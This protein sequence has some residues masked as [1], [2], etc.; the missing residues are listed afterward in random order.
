M[1]GQVKIG[2]E[3][4][5]KAK[6]DY[7]DWR[8]AW[9]RELAQNSWDIP[10]TKIITLTTTSHGNYT[11]AIWTNDGQPMTLDILL[12]KF[13]SLGSSGKNFEGT[14]GGYGKA[15][16]LL[17][18]CHKS[19]EIHTGSHL[20][21][22]IGGEYDIKEAEY[23][24]GTKTRVIM[25]GDEAEELNVRMRQYIPMCQWNGKVILNGEL[26]TDRLPKGHKR[27]QLSW[28]N[29]YTNNTYPEQMIVRIHGIPMFTRQIG[30]DKCV[31]VE[32]TDSY[33]VFT[34]NRDSLQWAYRRELD[35]FI[36]EINID[37]RSA[38]RVPE[39]TYEHFEGEKL[40]IQPKQESAAAKLIDEIYQSSPYTSC[41]RDYEDE[42]T[43]RIIITPTVRIDR[44]KVI[45]RVTRR[46]V[47]K[48]DFIIRNTTGM[49]IPNHYIPGKYF[50]TYSDK[51]IKFWARYLITIHEL[52]NDTRQFSIGFV[53]DEEDEALYERNYEYGTVYYINPAVVVRQTNSSS[54]SLSNRWK[55]DYP[56]KYAIAAAAGHEYIH[57]LGHGHDEDFANKLTT[58]TALLMSYIKMFR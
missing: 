41:T 38:L 19:W 55:F 35:A 48:I 24:Y 57:S 9:I 39:V 10:D 28:A 23:Y 43:G 14:V 31:L 44:D 36:D 12:N 2:P 20:V 33:R 16:E 56:G 4:F 21:I 53:F 1:R 52:H 58:I 11:E 30:L 8:T 51:L 22:G 34:A 54:R 13:L 3:F 50:S 49:E 25:E 42:N 15:K 37:K 17:A 47:S 26:I 29:I 32:V 45:G 27:R 46:L 18:F 6:L 5:A 40:E 7:S